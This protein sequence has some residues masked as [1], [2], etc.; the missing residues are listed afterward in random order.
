MNSGRLHRRAVALTG[1][2]TGGHC[3][4]PIDG[5]AADLSHGGH[6]AALS[7]GEPLGWDEPGYAGGHVDRPLGVVDLI[8]M[9]ATQ[10]HQ[11]VDVGGAAVL[12]LDHVVHLA[13]TRWSITPRMRAATVAGGDRAPDPDRDDAAGPTHIQRLTGLA[14]HHRDDLGITGQTAQLGR[15]ELAAH[16]QHRA[17]R[18]RLQV[19]QGDG[20]G[21]VRALALHLTVVLVIQGEPAHLHQRGRVP[22]RD[23]G[24]AVL[25]RGAGAGV[26]DGTDRGERARI[27]EHPVDR[28]GAVRVGVHAQHVLPGLVIGLG[29][30][31]VRRSQQLPPHDTDLTR[32]ARPRGLAEAVLDRHTI[33]RR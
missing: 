13:P 7:D 22:L 14:Q 18:P 32:G 15:G 11:V 25:R 33:S 16:G 9:G 12:P 17:P 26:E 2:H 28:T 20:H 27:V 31:H 21:Q 24:A 1:C 4:R 23:R 5:G 30:I 29:T 19:F 3:A 10:H 6:A 8:M